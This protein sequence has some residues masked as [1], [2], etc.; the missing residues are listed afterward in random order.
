MDAG[1]GSAAQRDEFCGTAGPEGSGFDMGAVGFA[2]TATPAA[3]T[4]TPASYGFGSVAVGL[5]GAA[6]PSHDFTLSNAG[7][8]TFTITNGGSIVSG[9][10]FSRLNA[11]TGNCGATLAAGASCTIRVRFHPSAATV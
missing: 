8:G 2:G 6:S 10:G 9:A 4:L 11:F 7:P 1:S 3:V 5:S